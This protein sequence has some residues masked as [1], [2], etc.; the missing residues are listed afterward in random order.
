MNVRLVTI[1]PDMAMEMLKNNPRNRTVHRMHLE[2]MCNELRAGRWKFNGD[3]IR[4][5][6]DGT[7]IDGQHRLLAVIA[8]GIAITTLLVT[9]LDPDVFDTIDSGARR[10][11]ADTLCVAGEK[12]GRNLAAALVVA[13]NLLTGKL[14]FSR[15]I[16]VSN[17]EILDM[18]ARHPEIRNS[19]HWGNAFARLAPPSIV[20]AL[21]YIVSI[22]AKDKADEF[23]TCVAKGE[24]LGFSNPAY[25]LRQRLIDNATAKGKLTRRYMAALF[26]KAWNSWRTGG[27]IKFLRFRESGDSPE[28]FPEIK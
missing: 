23:F 20:I 9:E 8:T 21:H 1:T 24:N 3:T 27:Q 19:V 7:L 22:R 16:K 25:L 26:I 4:V 5:G 6:I 10:S 2:S 15:V 11:G 12:N 13:D 28:T 18:L 17:A 14:D